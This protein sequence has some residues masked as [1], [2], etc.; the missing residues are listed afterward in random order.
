M[1]IGAATFAAAYLWFA[2]GPSGV[3]ALAPAFVLAGIGIGCAET[4]EHA[5]VASLAPA[6]LRGS[7]FGLLAGIQAAGNLGASTVAGALWTAVSPTAAFVFLAAAM[8]IAIPFV[9]TSRNAAVT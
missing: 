6:T 1:V 3:V 9:I 8:V 5:A 4:A 2:V 7:A